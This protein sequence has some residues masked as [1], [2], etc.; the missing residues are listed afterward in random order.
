VGE[1][2]S[3]SSSPLLEPLSESIVRQL[4]AYNVCTKLHTD[5]NM[6]CLEIQCG[7]ATFPPHSLFM[8][9]P[10]LSRVAKAL[11]YTLW[12]WTILMVLSVPV[13]RY[14]S[15]AGN[16]HPPTPGSYSVPPMNTAQCPADSRTDPTYHTML[17]TLGWA[18]IESSPLSNNSCLWPNNLT[19][20]IGSI[21]V[22]SV[23]NWWRFY[24]GLRWYLVARYR[25]ME[26]TAYYAWTDDVSVSV[27]LLD[28]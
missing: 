17:R 22:K 19:P 11:V 14:D 20:L 25:L 10:C 15:L 26:P 3:S 24:F 6:V 12:I 16:S 4:R 7:L 13:D 2:F 28:C 23:W 8:L 21:Y 9:D 27:Q 1:G 18:K 5:K